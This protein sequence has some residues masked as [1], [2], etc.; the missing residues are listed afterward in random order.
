MT[1]A[2]VTSPSG[3]AIRFTSFNCKGLNN[4]IKRSKILHHLYHLGAH[5][6]WRLNTCL[7]LNDNFVNF[8]SQQIDFFV[9]LNK[10]PEVSASVLWEALKAYIRGEIISYTGYEKK[11]RKEK[12]TKLTQRISELD[13]LYA[14]HKTPELYKER[15]CLQAEFDV[16]TTQRTTELLL[17]TRSQFYEHGDKASKLLAHRLRQESSSHLIP[18]IHTNSHNTTEPMEINNAFKEFYMSLYSSEQDSTPDFDNFFE[19][20]DIPS[21]DQSAVE[22]LERPITTA[23]LN[24]AAS[25]LQNGKSPGPD[26]F[27]SEF[28]KKFWH[29]LA[30][31]LLDMFNESFELGRLPQTLNQASISLLLKKGKDPLACSSYRPISLLNVD[32]KLLSKLLA[33]R[34]E[35]FLPSIIS[36]DQTG[37]IRNRHSFSNLRRLFNVLYNVSSSNTHEAVI[38][39][40]A[41][42]AFDRVEWDYLFHALEKFGFKNNFISWIKLL[43]SAP[44][45]SV[46]TNNIQSEYFHLYRSTRQGCPLSPL[47]FAIAIEP[48]SIALRSNPLITGLF[49][50]HTQ[51]KVSLYAD[52]LLLYLSNLSVSV[53]AAL[54]TLHS[55][56]QISGYKLNLNKSEIFPINPAAKMYPLKDFPFKVA[57]YSFVYLGVH[58]T[59]KFEDLYKANFA[60]LLIR[61]QKD[62]ERWSLLNL[63]LIA[64]V[65]SVKMNILPRLSYLFQCIPLF[66]PQSFFRK[67]DSRISDFIWNKKVP[68]LRKQYLQRPKSLGGLALPNL[69]FYYWA[70]NIRTLKYWLE[71]EAFDPPPIWLV[72][73]AR[74]ANPVS[75]KALV[76][77]PI[78]SSTLPYTKNVIVKASLRIWVQFKRYFGLQTFSV[79]APLAANHAFPPSLIDCVFLRWSNFGIH[80]FKDLYI[81]NVFATFQQLSDKFSLPKQ[82][83]FRYLQVRSFVH[84]TFPS[85]PNL[86]SDLTLDSFLTPIPTLKGSISYIYNQIN[87]LCSEPLD[88]IKSHWEEDLGA[89]I[90]EEDWAEILRRVHKSSICARHSLIQCKLVHLLY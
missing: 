69:R 73:E 82:H 20:L 23:E 45:A 76:H 25:S 39:L 66:L 58:V 47:L 52:D 13:R 9:S 65:N 21:L 57:N 79:Y 84:G 4:P 78:H 27:P 63:S 26:G 46:R 15:L 1:S 67:L 85:F 72:M 50:H 54:A 49:R 34:L 61:I 19:N 30:P 60:P 8:V 42:K 11:L 37:F 87:T 44:Q 24:T 80:N 68:R 59:H 89:A 74:S 77:S 12:L 16:L 55:F 43:Y 36:L 18:Q 17:Q 70:T 10:T 83:F 62:F 7:L 31:L 33:L 86:P 64:R 56:G 41:E 28:F 22:K 90:S 5:A 40:D 81:N 14:T 29:K 38:S 2:N 48:L 3:C 53:P 51:V 88:L 6:P 35:S 32:F 71:Y 75:L